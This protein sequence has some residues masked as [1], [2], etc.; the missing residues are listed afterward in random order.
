MYLL[1]TVDESEKSTHKGHNSF[2]KFDEYKDTQT[3]KEVTK[4]NMRGFKSKNHE[5]FT[6]KSNK[7]SLM[8]SDIFSPM[9]YILYH[10]VTK[11][12]Q[13]ENWSNKKI[14]FVNS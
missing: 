2:I 12:Y 3:N 10:M 7:I 1:K 9:E 14:Y 6:Y 8:I 4:N 11:T 5:I 13:Q